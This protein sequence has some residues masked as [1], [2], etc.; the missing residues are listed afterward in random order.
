MR[1]FT[2]ANDCQT[3]LKKYEQKTFDSNSKPQVYAAAHSLKRISPL[4]KDVII[5]SYLLIV[6]Q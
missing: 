1:P 2:L 6:R 4:Q 5:C 3:D